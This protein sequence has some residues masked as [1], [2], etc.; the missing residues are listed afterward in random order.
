MCG[1]T[2]TSLSSCHNKQ[3]T[4][5][6]ITWHSTPIATGKDIGL[7]VCVCNNVIMMSFSLWLVAKETHEKD[8]CELA[9]A[10]HQ[11]RAGLTPTL[12]SL[13]ALKS[14]SIQIRSWLCSAPMLPKPH[15]R[16]SCMSVTQT[17]SVSSAL[18]SS[19]QGSEASCAAMNTT[20][21]GLT[22]WRP[23]CSMSVDWQPARCHNQL[24][25]TFDFDILNCIY[26]TVAAGV[27]DASSANC[28]SNQP[29]AK[30][31]QL[32]L[33]SHGRL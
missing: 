12:P 3:P 6:S 32:N 14:I 20:L 31:G 26:V 28:Q 13:Q 33:E 27:G 4:T 17:S 23:P 11:W 16:N 22:L 1:P 5:A 18:M 29:I 9:K 8:W 25:T 19:F 7:Q 10:L 15:V 2:A 24:L 30:P 21:H